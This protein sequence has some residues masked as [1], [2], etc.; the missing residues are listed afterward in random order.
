MTGSFR[1]A[2]FEFSQNLYI[3]SSN[4]GALGESLFT[5]DHRVLK[6]TI[7]LSS[8]SDA[9]TAVATSPCRWRHCAE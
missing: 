5:V 3:V 8:A 7:G 2:K 4:I 9:Q 1:F 6:Q